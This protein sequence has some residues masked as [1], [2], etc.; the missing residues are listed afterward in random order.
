MNSQTIFYLAVILMPFQIASLSIDGVGFDLSSIFFFAFI[1]AIS[2]KGI[3]WVNLL[4]ILLFYVWQFFIFFVYPVAPTPRFLSS[5]IWVG[6]MILGYFVKIKKVVDFSKTYYLIVAGGMINAVVMYQEFFQD[7]ERPQ[8]FFKEPSFAG[9]FMYGVSAGLIYLFISSPKSFFKVMQFVL[10][11][12][13]LS[14]A[15]MTK[16]SH[17]VAFTIVFVCMA[18]FLWGFLNIKKH[19]FMTSMFILLTLTFLYPIYFSYHFQDR[20]AGNGN[21]STWNWFFGMEQAV[22]V[23][24]NAPILGM[25]AGSTGEFDFPTDYWLRGI[26]WEDSNVKDAYSLAFRVIIE[27]GFLFFIIC[28]YK[29]IKIF[30]STFSLIALFSKESLVQ[31]QYQIFL[32]IFSSTLLIG[33]LIK[34]PLFSRSYVFGA[35]FI[36]FLSSSYILSKKDEIF[37]ERFH[38]NVALI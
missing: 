37:E 9:L 5:V 26:P 31:S 27:Y 29:L 14:A 7:I 36:Y 28:L 13:F 25:G 6:G 17:V 24:Q 4:K 3:Y 16:T 34:E 15:I 23:I 18:I 8:G 2:L 12:F 19:F 30:I 35:F 22:Y 1:V 33:D 21:L 32:F 20:L 38:K 10:A 11:L